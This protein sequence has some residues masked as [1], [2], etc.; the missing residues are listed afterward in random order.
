MKFKYQLHA[1]TYP[2]SDCAQ[3]SMEELIES[4]REG[5]YQG[6]VITNHFLHG[7]SGIDRSLSWED[8]VKEYEND[9]L[10]GKELAE[11][12]GLDLI[13]GLEE[14]VGGGL[15]ILCYGIT[16]QLL[17]SHPE[18][19][20]L[21]V[22]TWHEVL[23]SN[24]ALVIQ[25]HPFRQRDYILKPSVLPEEFIDGIEVFNR[26]NLAED[27]ETARLAAQEHPNWILVSGSD[28]HRN[29]STCRA[30]IECDERI[31]NEKELVSML[32]SGKYRLITE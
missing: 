6:C 28:S 15:E 18:L 30:G 14:G 9:Y 8:F 21:G 5:G 25:A 3:R 27:N 1:H 31:T 2:C 26:E 19:S 22:K 24:G 16:P 20:A 17:Y 11:K 29:T 23:H 10:R 13:F 32:K 7:N 4:L 12:Y